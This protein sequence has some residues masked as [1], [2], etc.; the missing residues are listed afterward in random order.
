VLISREGT[1]TENPLVSVVV[2]VYNGEQYLATALHSILVQ[3]YRPIEIIIVDDGSTD[4]SADIV[5]SLAQAHKEIRYLYQANQ[6]LAVSLNRGIAAG[7][8]EFFAFL[9]H[10]DLWMQDKLRIQVNH[11][12][13]HPHVG[14]SLT[15]MRWF[16]E[17]GV[18]PPS[19]SRWRP[20]LLSSDLPGFVFGTMLVRST[21]LE[22]VGPLDPQYQA[23]DADWFAR[24]KDVGVPVT[25]LPE[26]LL[27][28]RIHD[29]NMS[30]RHS[31]L[32]S[33]LLR[34][35]KTS[36]DRRRAQERGAG[37]EY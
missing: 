1:V 23:N 29:S 21:V 25:I 4:S 24:A 36:I 18:D 34:I 17:P 28:K 3:D 20:D 26:T 7:H 15:R 37:S 27:H 32:R 33:D 12:F 16:L 31:I 11:L 9:D 5:Q 8:G 10:D 19:W 6:G 35:F 30:H 2:P 13:E 14:Y 22:Q